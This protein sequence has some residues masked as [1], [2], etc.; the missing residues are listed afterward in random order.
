MTAATLRSREV[1]EKLVPINI[2]NFQLRLFDIAGIDD[3][4]ADDKDSIVKHLKMLEAALNQEGPF[5]ILLFRP[6]NGRIKPGDFV[7]MKTV[8]ES[9]KEG[10][11]MGLILTQARHTDMHQY[12]SPTHT[13]MVL[14][15]LEK[16]VDKRSKKLLSREPPLVLADHDERGFSADEKS[17]SSN[18]SSRSTPSWL[19]RAT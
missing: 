19:T 5:V 7:I 9:L 16:I 15:P 12:R 2:K 1:S 18:L 6:T 17:I 11:Q 13:R 14:G 8:F 10:P 3:C 4:S